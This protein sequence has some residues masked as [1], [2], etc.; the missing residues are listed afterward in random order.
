[1]S[2]IP[3]LRCLLAIAVALGAAA[4][5][6]ALLWKV[7]N[8]P[9]PPTAKRAVD[10]N[11]QP[12]VAAVIENHEDARPFQEGL[13]EAETVF[14]VLVEGE[15][16]RFLTLYRADRIPERL[17]PVR[18]LRH[19]F[20]D[21]VAPYRPLLL[22]IGASKEAYE[23]LLTSP[24]PSHDGIRYDGE[25]YER[26][27]DASRPHNLFMPRIALQEVL[28]D[29]AVPSYPFPLFRE[30]PSPEGGTG[31]IAI[32]VNFKSS[33]H[34]VAFTYD[35]GSRDYIRSVY[36]A[37]VQSHPETV[38]ILE[39]PIVDIG[40]LGKLSLDTVGQG[41]MLLFREGKSYEGTWQRLE[42]GPFTFLRPDGGLLP[43]ARGQTWILLFPD[44]TRVSWRTT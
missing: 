5:V 10:P 11:L 30:G 41:K 7:V 38:A 43:V 22:H 17:G 28:Q 3:F 31:T 32:S 12:V 4:V 8:I 20:L 16:S 34:N 35:P 1:M 29:F 18:S 26:D 24:F 23:A 14:E 9:S 2:S 25:T 44:L 21:V 15:I 33:Y 42:G 13:K 19:D 27:T 40:A 6:V 37:P 36:N 39:V